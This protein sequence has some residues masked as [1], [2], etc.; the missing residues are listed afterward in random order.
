VAFDN[1]KETLAV[2]IATGG[3]RGEVWFWGTIPNQAEA[4]RKLVAKLVAKH[5]VLNFCYEAE[6]CGYGLYR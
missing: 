5:P 3:L 1:S 6:P 4:V 2:A